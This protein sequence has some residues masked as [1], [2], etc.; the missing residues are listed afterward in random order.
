MRRCQKCGYELGATDNACPEC[1][2]ENNSPL[3]VQLNQ[4]EGF[5]KPVL[6]KVP[7][8]FNFGAFILGGIWAFG[9]GLWIHGIVGVL[10]FCLPGINLLYALYL[11]FFG[12]RLAWRKSGS[13][14]VEKFRKNQGK[15]AWGGVVYLCLVAF[16]LTKLAQH[17]IPGDKDHFEICRDRI[18]SIQQGELD[19]FKDHGEYTDKMELL[20]Y[21]IVPDCFKKEG[22]GNKLGK[23]VSKSCD[24]VSIQLSK[25]NRAP[26]FVIKGKAKDRRKCSI[27]V[28]EDK[29]TPLSFRRCGDGATPEQRC[30]EIRKSV[31]K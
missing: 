31:K 1:G 20:D 8:G 12:N 4:Y 21:Y 16:L 15:W 29:V 26:F 17:I 19:Y 14:N 3:N 9:H 10:L 22:C 23:I 30:V 2:T 25:N 18:I 11:G 5:V 6:I 7:G 27:C 13:Y 28:S 24:N